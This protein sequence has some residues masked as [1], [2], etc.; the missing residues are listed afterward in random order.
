MQLEQ[1]GCLN[2]QE[3]TILEENYSFLRKLEHRLQIM[4]DLQTHLMP[5]ET[6]SC[7]SWPCG[8]ATPTC[9]TAGPLEPSWPTSTKRPF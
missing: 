2:H 8:W 4:F 3:R 6:R 7:G 5:A 9:P 1:A